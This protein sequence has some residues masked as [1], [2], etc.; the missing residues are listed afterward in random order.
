MP[1]PAVYAPPRPAATAATVLLALSGAAVLF[2]LVADF[3]LYGAAGDLGTDVDPVE[4]GPFVDAEQFFKT[5]DLVDTVV[6]LISAVTFIIWFYRVR[7]NAEAFHPHG[8]RFR[9][10]WAI[11]AWFT[12]LVCLWFPRQIA[13][14]TWQASVRPDESGVRPPLSQTLLNAWW[15]TFWLANLLDRLGSQ[16]KST[17]HWADDY[18]QSVVWLIASDVLELVGAVLAILVVRKLTEMQERYVTEPA[19]RAYGVAVTEV[20]G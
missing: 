6:L 3:R 14:D 2:R 13:G 11:G 1:S 12:P 19:A 17:A 16:Y 9:R 20:R 5:A 7:V 8:H 18:Q 10:G 4:V 15:T